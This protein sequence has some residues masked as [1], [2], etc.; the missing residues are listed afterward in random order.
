MHWLLCASLSITLALFLL[1]HERLRSHQI[2]KQILICQDILCCTSSPTGMMMPYCRPRQV[3]TFKHVSIHLH[4]MHER[5]LVMVKE[6]CIAIL[7]MFIDTYIP[8]HKCT[9]ICCGEGEVRECG[10]I[11]IDA[12]TYTHTHTHLMLSFLCNASH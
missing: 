8:L 9:H 2:S 6:R 1:Y 11:A 3:V 4:I 10:F 5:F 7:Q 12:Y